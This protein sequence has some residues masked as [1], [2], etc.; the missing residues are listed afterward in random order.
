MSAAAVVFIMC[1]FTAALLLLRG[2]CKLKKR[3]NTAEVQKEQEM[4]NLTIYEEIFAREPTFEVQK[5]DAY[6]KVT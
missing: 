6:A 5:N 1:S 2:L 3:A 4:A